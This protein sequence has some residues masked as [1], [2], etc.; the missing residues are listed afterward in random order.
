M[1]ISYSSLDWT[2][3][4]S[5]SVLSSQGQITTLRD[6]ART[7]SLSKDKDEMYVYVCRQDAV[8]H[9]LFTKFCK[10]IFCFFFIYF[11]SQYFEAPRI[12][13]GGTRGSVVG[14]DTILQSG[15]SLVRFPMRSLIFQLT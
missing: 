3:A 4:A 15:R 8:T 7:T 12:V 1:K 2:A 9:L 14:R 10:R 13:S 6:S 5:L 11:P